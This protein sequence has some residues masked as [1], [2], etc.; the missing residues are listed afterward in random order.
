MFTYCQT[1]GEKLKKNHSSQTVGCLGL[2]ECK[3]CL[4]LCKSLT[5]SLNFQ[6]DVVEVW[7]S[8][9]REINENSHLLWWTGSRYMPFTHTAKCDAISQLK[10]VPRVGSILFPHHSKQDASSTCEL[11][12]AK[13]LGNRRTE[14]SQHLSEKV[15]DRKKAVFSTL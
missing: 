11:M 7:G 15:K 10:T 13:S 8:L 9:Q 14:G 1:S 2:H 6:P 5:K 3:R 4:L 12:Q